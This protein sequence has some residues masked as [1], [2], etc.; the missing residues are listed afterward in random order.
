MKLIKFFIKLIFGNHFTNKL[1]LFK[2]ALRTNYFRATRKLKSSEQFNKKYGTSIERYAADFG[3]TYFGYYDITPFSLNNQYLLAQVVPSFHTQDVNKK[4]IRI[5]YFDREAKD[6]FNEVDQTT[7]W[8]WQQGCRLQWFPKNENEL[9]F[10]NKIIE[11]NYGSVVQN[12]KNKKIIQR[13]RHP[14]YDIDSSGSL[15]LT[16]NFSRLQRLRPGY[17]YSNY[18][19]KT[20]G[21]KIPDDDGIWRIDM[22]SGLSECIITLDQLSKI[23]PNDSMFNAQHYVNHLSSNP[24]GTRFMFFHLWTQN[25]KRYNRMLT[26]DYEGKNLHILEDQGNVSHYSWKNDDEII[27][28]VYLPGI[29][30]RYKKYR[31]LSNQKEVLY[32]NLLKSDGH[33][34]YSP[35]TNDLL[36]DTYPDKYR[37]LYLFLLTEKGKLKLIEK[38]YSPVKFF[39]E[40]RCD[41]H[42]RWDRIG[43]SA[44]VDSTH[45]GN[46]A[47]YV[48]N[49][50]NIE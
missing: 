18:I 24:S 30:C 38:F 9:I 10:Y 2:A 41:L 39:G 34:S 46:R 33:P 36:L 16:L 13:Y 20:E 26:C 44:C 32:D 6:G 19:D 4:F 28:T 21:V 1:I 50:K 15:G 49:V 29:G 31:D 37:E 25:E 35:R 42:P 8:C 5:G 7:T 27:A 3:Q 22:N 47:L 11:Q 45:D 23:K 14:I 17:G 40:V 12:I 48:I 43:E